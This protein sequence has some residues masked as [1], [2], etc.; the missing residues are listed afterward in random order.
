[1]VAEVSSHPPSDP[2]WPRASSG[3]DKAFLFQVH[4][5]LHRWPRP[6]A[7]WCVYCFKQKGTTKDHITPKSQG[8]TRDWWN[9]APACRDCNGRRGVVPFLVFMIR[10]RA[11]RAAMRRRRR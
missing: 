5:N 4:Q 6:K 10:R 11:E 3:V 2:L 8:G 1:M 9:I 7:E